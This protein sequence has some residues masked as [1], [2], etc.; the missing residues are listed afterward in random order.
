MEDHECI[1]EVSH[2]C[3]AECRALKSAALR[4]GAQTA[5]VSGAASGGGGG[6]D[7]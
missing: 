5:A 3:I 6:K 1:S 4:G 2:A 7:S